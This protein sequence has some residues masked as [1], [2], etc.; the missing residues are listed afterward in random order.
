MFNKCDEQSILSHLFYLFSSICQA[1]DSVFAPPAVEVREMLDSS[2][3]AAC[4]GFLPSAR[5]SHSNKECREWQTSRTRRNLIMLASRRSS[6]LI[7]LVVSS[8]AS[9][10]V[11]LRWHEVRHG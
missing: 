7:L 10:A 2:D 5:E 8:A 6:L 11:D 1:K 9:A 4:A 3:G